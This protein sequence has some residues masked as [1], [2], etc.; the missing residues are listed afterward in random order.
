MGKEREK[1]KG[2]G[3]IFDLSEKQSYKTKN[4]VEINRT[5]VSQMNK[6]H[7]RPVS[8]QGHNETRPASTAEDIPSKNMFA[9]ERGKCGET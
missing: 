2:G 4:D 1:K 8:L 7:E 6:F 3:G 5:A 9:V